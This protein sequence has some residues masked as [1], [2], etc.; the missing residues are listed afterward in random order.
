MYV[1]NPKKPETVKVRV[2]TARSGHQPH[3]SGNGVHQDKRLHR[4]NTRQAQ[5]SAA[6]R[7]YE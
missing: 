2:T 6:M 5:K 4:L 1:L 3:R 7:D